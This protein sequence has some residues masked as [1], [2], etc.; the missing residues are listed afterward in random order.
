MEY[1]GFCISL[2]QETDMKRRSVPN[3]GYLLHIMRIYCGKYIGAT[4]HTV[5]KFVKPEIGYRGLQKPKL[6]FHIFLLKY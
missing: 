1:L 2:Q 3:R 4:E 5:Y 6:K